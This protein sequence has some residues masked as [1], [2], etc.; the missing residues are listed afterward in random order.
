[1]SQRPD[2]GGD[3]VPAPGGELLVG[4]V[5]EG[6]LAQRVSSI[7]ERA[8]ATVA[9]T[10]DAPSALAS[11]CPDRPP[12]VAVVSDPRDLPGC[13]RLLARRMPRTRVVLL[14]RRRDRRAVE[15]ALRLGAQA[16]VLY[17][18]APRVLPLVV[19]AVALDQSSVPREMT[20]VL[21]KAVARSAHARQSN[22][23]SS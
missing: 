10:V 7:L 14:L 6:P 21:R 13:L 9:A 19:R 1:M 22:G 16:A 3:L 2:I 4:V 15:M 17:D 20:A 11:A 5:A 18:Q 8:G 23:V 12:H